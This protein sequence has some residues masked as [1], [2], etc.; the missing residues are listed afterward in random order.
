MC[1]GEA[2]DPVEKKKGWRSLVMK[3]VVV[4]RVTSG[5]VVA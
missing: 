1:G 3:M 4:V 2:I 5:L